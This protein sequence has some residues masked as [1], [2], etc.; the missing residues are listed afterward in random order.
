VAGQLQSAQHFA[1][2]TGRLLASPVVRNLAHCAVPGAMLSCEKREQ[3]FFSLTHYTGSS[4][5]TMVASMFAT[6]AFLVTLV[7]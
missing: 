5:N 2:T 6:L 1:A 4:T 3:A 7:V